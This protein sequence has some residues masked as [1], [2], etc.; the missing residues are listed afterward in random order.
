MT[1]RRKGNRANSGASPVALP[2]WDRSSRAHRFG[3]RSLEARA[4]ALARWPIS[5]CR[6]FARAFDWVD[7]GGG[8]YPFSSAGKR[9]TLRPPCP[10]TMTLSPGAAVV[11]F[12]ATATTKLTNRG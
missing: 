6:C 12:G 11:R 10:V 9:T 4:R 8:T 2:S 3:K 1:S 5:L 7:V